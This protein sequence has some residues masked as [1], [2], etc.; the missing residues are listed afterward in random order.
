[1]TTTT[2]VYWTYKGVVLNNLAWSIKTKG[3][4][5]MGT[6]DPRGENLAVPGVTGRM[7]L[8]KLRD[9]RII[10]LE[11]W[12]VGSDIDG[13]RPATRAGLDTQF[14]GNWETLAN[15]FDDDGQH[16]LV[17]RFRHAG[18][19]TTAT[20][21]AE[22]AGG[23]D[24]DMADEYKADL[25]PSLL[26][27]DPW[28]YSAAVG[29]LT[30]AVTIQGN[31]PTDHVT[32]GLEPGERVTWGGGSRW[33]QNDHTGG[34]VIDIREKAA[35]DGSTYVNGLIS[36]D[37]TTADW[38]TLIPGAQTFTFTEGGSFDYEAAWR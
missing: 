24:P 8:P 15:L 14:D 16:P 19:I 1:M 9:S 11:M 22:Y 20:A 37:R 26:L 36:R 13:G 17:K 5:R 29:G 38:M 7:W 3:G 10:T 32:L 28:F 12:V 23:L 25:S 27:A 31:K 35:L 21:L 6:A 33:I 4:T 18:G 2:D 34:V 30:G